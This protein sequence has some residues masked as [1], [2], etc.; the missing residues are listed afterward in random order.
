MLN[1]SDRLATLFAKD[2]KGFHCLLAMRDNQWQGVE[3]KQ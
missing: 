3:V 1:F 2:G